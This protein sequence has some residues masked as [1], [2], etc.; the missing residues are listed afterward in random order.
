MLLGP[1]RSKADTE[2]DDI[3]SR[4]LKLPNEIKQRIWTLAVTVDEP[5]TP[6]QFRSKSNKFLWS[7]NQTNQENDQRD[8][9]AVPQLVAVQLAKV[10]RQLYQEI[11]A[12]QLF[13]KVNDFHF[14]K[15]SNWT[16]SQT[17]LTYLV[18]ITEPRRTAIRSIKFTWHRW[19]KATGSHVFTLLTACHGLQSLDMKLHWQLR[20]YNISKYPPPGFKESLVAVQG[21]KKLTLSAGVTPDYIGWA[22][23]SQRD[24]TKELRDQL[25]ALFEEHMRKPRSMT[26]N[27]DKFR[28]AQIEANLDVHGEGRLCKDKKPGVIS[29][30]TR[31]QLRNAEN[32]T[33]DGT[34]PERKSPK[35]DLN[36]DLAW[37]IVI[38]EKSREVSLGGSQSVEFLIKGGP[39][40]QDNR[41]RIQEDKVQK[42]WEDVTTM[43]SLNCRYE[44]TDFYQKNPKAFGKQVVLDVWKLRNLGAGSEDKMKGQTEKRLEAMIRHQA[45]AEQREAEQA[46]RAACQGAKDSEAIKTSKKVKKAKTSKFL[47]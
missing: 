32:L 20:Y 11:A 26:Y 22:T 36:G 5:I 28:Q 18:A 19:S 25:E 24:E 4:L 17:P 8:V 15:Y 1:D 38:I 43:N 9:S 41:W 39:S 29:S 31:Q 16:I 21:L 13:Y 6:I 10:C 35:Y 42:F 40:Y 14:I 37:C 2:Q 3:E 12:T 30:R 33:A 34:L 7:I 27:L 47:P 45:L 23:L 44:I 46:A